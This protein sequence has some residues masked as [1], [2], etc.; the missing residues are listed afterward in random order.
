MLK[1]RVTIVIKSG[2]GGHGSL[3]TNMDFSVGGDGGNGG[4]IILK[5]DENL[6]DLSALDDSGEYKAERGEDGGKRRRTGNKGKDKVILVPLTTE[7]HIENR[8]PYKVTKHRQKIKILDGGKGGI[9]S[10]TLSKRH[11]SQ[12]HGHNGFSEGSYGH[13]WDAKFASLDA[14][15]ND[16]AHQHYLGLAGKMKKITLVLKL[17][18]DAIFIG[19]PNA[20]KSSLLN[21]LTNAHVKTASYAFTTLSPQIALMDGLRLMD[22]PGLIEGTFEGKG[23]GTS[24]VKHTESSKLVAHVI[25]YENEKPM[26]MYK[27]MRKELKRIDPK[28]FD[29]PEM[30]ILSK[31]DEA[32][33]KRIAKTEKAFVKI[34][35]DVVSVNVID[36]PALAKLKTMLQEQVLAAAGTSYYPISEKPAAGDV[37]EKEDQVG[38]QVRDK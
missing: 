25:S 19:Y 1:D 7:V 20:G 14:S 37:T 16:E 9:G 17:L 18:A 24:W 23:L 31:S 6:Y 38:Y 3:A 12:L 30:I 29:K 10:V 13:D 5:G 11:Y 35:K 26:A 27:S 34:G 15:S 4:N 28:L 32:D 36:E 2:K 33:E 22:L 21:S 8:V